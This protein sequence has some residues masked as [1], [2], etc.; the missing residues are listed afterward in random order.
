MSAFRLS[1]RTKKIGTAS[2]EILSDGAEVWAL[3]NTDFEDVRDS[4]Q[5]RIV[6]EHSVIIE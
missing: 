3:K 6:T 1:F 4:E 5:V 2:F